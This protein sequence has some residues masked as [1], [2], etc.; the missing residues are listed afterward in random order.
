M[1]TSVPNICRKF[2]THS[3][4]LLA[5]PNAKIL[6]L[7]NDG[8]EEVSYED[9]EHYRVTKQFLDDPK[10]MLD[11]LLADDLEELD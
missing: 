2:A 10:R 3:P 1:T 6:Q 4:I 7:S 11:L 9:T 5:Y 8:I